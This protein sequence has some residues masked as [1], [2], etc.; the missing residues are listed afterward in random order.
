MKMLMV[1]VAAAL[2]A[3][4]CANNSNETAA[5]PQNPP[6][7]TGAIALAT[8]ESKSGSTMTGTAKFVE[9]NGELTLTL[10]VK[11]ATPGDHGVHL[12]ET[13]DCSAPDGKSAGAH[14]NPENA[15]HGGPTGGAHHAGDLG[16]F[17]VKDDGTGTLTLTTKDLTVAPGPHS[18]VGRAIVIH[19]KA[20][21]LSSQPAGNSGAR[22]GCGVISGS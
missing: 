16:N 18:V 15:Q 22:V 2:A 10:E 17:K 19:E 11:G 20:D 4:A 5:H 6:P 14:F 13:P 21:D 9:N 1:V 7:P 12:H 3:S 8:I